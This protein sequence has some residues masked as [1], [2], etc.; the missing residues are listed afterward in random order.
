M[1]TLGYD[2]SLFGEERIQINNISP[3]EKGDSSDLSFCSSDDKEGLESILNSKSG[4]I[5][6][7]K[8]LEDYIRQREGFDNNNSGV[9]RLFVFVD[10]PRLVFIRMAKIMKGYKDIRKGISKH[11]I[12]SDSAKMGSDCHIGDFTIIGDDCIMGNNTVIGSKVL[13]KNAKVG[14]NCI[15]LS[16]NTIGEEGFAFEREEKH[17]ELERFPHFGKVVIEDNVEIFAN[18]SIAQGSISDT[19]IEQGSKIDAMC[20]IAHNV[21]IGKNTQVTA[22]TVIGGSTSIGSNCWLGLNSTIKHKLKIGNGVIVGSGSSVIHDVEDK[23]IV[24]GSP[25]KSIKDKITLNQ[26]KLFLMRGQDNENEIQ[27]HNQLQDNTLPKKDPFYQTKGI[28]I[29]KRI[30]WSILGMFLG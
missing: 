30:D 6:C 11:A 21:H 5:L 8:T 29:S 9:P 16:G 7:K 3:I 24:A 19:V 23:D 1:N 14:N 28:D 13:L 25:A 26:D 10:N 2:Y 18:C 22:G 20:H 27:N 12:I 4:I 15:I 17:M